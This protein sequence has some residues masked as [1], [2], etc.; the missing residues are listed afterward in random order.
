MKTPL[1][2]STAP[3]SSVTSTTP[4]PDGGMCGIGRSQLK[5]GLQWKT[6]Q[7][8][9]AFLWTVMQGCHG[10][11]AHGVIYDEKTQTW[12]GRID[13][14]HEW[15]LQ[16]LI[17]VTARFAIGHILKKGKTLK[18]YKFVGHPICTTYTSPSTSVLPKPSFIYLLTSR[19]TL[20]AFS[21]C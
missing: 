16:N 20:S 4:T 3:A 6:M 9:R 10:P 11:M 15:V 14:D 5:F 19:I 12:G 21:T 18:T 13:S 17:E 2:E 8:K 7:G 1:T